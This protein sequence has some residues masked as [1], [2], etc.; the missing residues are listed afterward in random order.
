MAA[1]QRIAAVLFGDIVGSTELWNTDRVLAAKAL[2]NH[3]RVVVKL[4]ASCGGRLFKHTGD[5]FAAEF[6]DPV[7]A[8]DCAARLLER[9][10]S[11]RWPTPCPV[12]VRLGL[13]V[14]TV[15]VVEEDLFGPPVNRAARMAGLG[16]RN[17]VAIAAGASAL[18]EVD[19]RS[20]PIEYCGVVELKGFTE[21]QSVHRLV[22]AGDIALPTM[23]RKRPRHPSHASEQTGETSASMVGR[24]SELSE[25]AHHLDR[26][27]E[28]HGSIVFIGGEPGLGKTVLARCVAAEA[29]ARDIAV[30]WG[31]C[32]EDRGAPSLWPWLQV[33]SAL[34]F[35]RADLRPIIGPTGDDLAALLSGAELDRGGADA[36]LSLSRRF[37][38]LEGIRTLIAASGGPVCVLLEDI[39]RAD[40]D[41][42][43]AL[44]HIGEGI[45]LE[46]IVV[47][48]TVRD[49]EIPK[50]SHL[51]GVMGRLVASASCSYLGLTALSAEESA[52]HAQRVL[53]GASVPTGVIASAIRRSGG[54]PFFLEELL[55][56][57]GAPGT[58][59]L[60][61]TIREAIRSRVERL[62]G[63]GA[64]LLGR[65]AVLG[66][67]FDEGDATE[68]ADDDPRAIAVALAAAEDARLLERDGTVLRF[69]HVLV[70]DVL[71][72]TLPLED[73][74]ATHIRLASRSLGVAATPEELLDRAH[75]ARAANECGANIDVVEPALAAGRAAAA[76][77]LSQATEWFEIALADRSIGVRSA[78]V[79]VELGTA[80]LQAGKPE[81]ARE[82]FETAFTE[83]E[84]LGEQAT[85]I[86]AAL[87][88]GKSVVTAGAVDRPLVSMLQRTR[89]VLAAH[90]NDAHARLLA[91]E[92]I[93]LYWHDGD[94][95]RELTA[96]AMALIGPATSPEVAAEVYHARL[97]CLRGPGR[98]EE[99]ISLGTQLVEIANTSQLTDEEFRGRA[100]LIPELLQRP[101]IP[102][103][104]AQ[105]RS[106]SDLAERTNQPLHRWYAELYQAQALIARGDTNEGLAVAASALR[107]GQRAQASVSS[108]YHIGQEYLARRDI[109][110]I[111]PLAEGIRDL[112]ERFPVFATLR[113]VL[114]L[115]YIDIGRQEEAASEVTR[116]A[117]QRFAI[118]PH[119]SLW[120]ATLG[121]C[122]EVSFRARL[123]STG[124]LVA[125]LLKP[126]AGT[127]AVQGLP[128]C[129]GSVDR[130]IGLGLASAGHLEPARQHLEHAVHQ[131]RQWGFVPLR[132]RTQ[133]DLVR[134]TQLEGP[135]NRT[136]LSETEHEL[137]TI[138]A[139]ADACGLRRISNEAAELHLLLSNVEPTRPAGPGG[140][141][142]PRETEILEHIAKGAT[143]RA[144]TEQLFISVN[145]VERHLRNIFNKLGVTNRAGATAALMQHNATN[146]RRAAHP[147][148]RENHGLP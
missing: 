73:R 119:D 97:F 24:R 121:M 36:Q 81:R 136:Q 94:H 59:E 48:G 28:G 57:A 109:G 49:N 3:D 131:H 72:E 23:V 114:A 125:T 87:G 27:L 39:H 54:H 76:L 138:S 30:V 44:E 102:S 142:T 46:S 55:R 139:E 122:G 60:P 146:K 148:G 33:L 112:S 16:D 38:L 75:H 144:L 20:L 58:P 50:D 77:G 12:H 52:Q 9:L 120:I 134:L 127:C 71:Y 86:A 68:V 37:R 147:T 67:D 40:S 53:N 63:A 110:G 34:G 140:T 89:A 83:A 100:W 111:E 13:D 99:R 61:L 6:R 5:G 70:R 116:L 8:L 74:R 69:R 65:V 117:N 7:N 96:A 91:R 98:L 4:V 90:D 106:L 107:H 10:A 101:D 93:E 105:I 137:N 21:P 1:L 25:I 92:G 32:R 78:A 47:I 82:C 129:F 22:T 45:D 132:L 124:A 104:H 145:T 113:A 143:N 17:A 51:A 66:R 115:L 14:G 18:L 130:Y 108:V 126:H 80:H 118:V 41:S 133:L 56:S 62:P 42:L 19:S 29:D 88:V 103:Y 128:C 135:L 79:R 35:Q 43:D 64:G 31:R 26:T 11:T 2:S 123:P 15:D 84:A 95:S 141:L 85:L